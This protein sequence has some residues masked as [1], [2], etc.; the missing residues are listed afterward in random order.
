MLFDTHCH[1]YDE[2]FRDGLDLVIDQAM[3]AG[4]ACI[5]VPGIDVRT[6]EQA[7][8]LAGKYDIIYAAVGIHAE[9]AK[10]VP[11]AD[12]S[13]IEALAKEKKVVAIGEIGL[14]YYWNVAPPEI[15]QEVLRR[16]IDLARRTSLPVIIH[17]RDATLDTVNLLKRECRGEV[18]GIMHCFTGSIETAR[19]CIDLGFYIS[20]GGSVTFKNAR[21]VQEVASQVVESRLLIETDAPYMTPHP[22]RGTRNEPA[23]VRLVAE[24][25]AELRDVDYESLTKLT[26]ANAERLFF[27][28]GVS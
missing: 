9:A 18:N 20:F 23:H 21:N 4:V 13:Q 15:Q 22:H 5:V 28:K 10:D 26:Y 24:K 3:M 1:L 19:Q 7:I 14:D 25:L 27:T 11:E 17:N 8:A 12:F 2:K 16:Q 6:S